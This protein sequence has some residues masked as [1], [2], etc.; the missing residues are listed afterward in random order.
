MHAVVV[1]ALGIALIHAVEAD[2]SIGTYLTGFQ[3]TYKSIRFQ[4]T[5]TLRG[6]TPTCYVTPAEREWSSQRTSS[7]TPIWL[8]WAPFFASKHG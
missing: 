2:C 5:L 8:N 3:P 6:S 7:T 1:T 4:A